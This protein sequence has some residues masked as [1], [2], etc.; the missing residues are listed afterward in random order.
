MKVKTS[1]IQAWV[2]DRSKTMAPR[3]LRLFVTMVRGAFNAAVI[4]RLVAATPFQRIVLPK[5]ERERVVPL[6]VEQVAVVDE[7]GDQYKA[8][9]VT[10]AGLGLRIGELLTLRAEDVDFL[11]REVRIVHQIDRTTREFVPP[12]TARSRRTVPL[13]NVV[14]LELA[15]HI[16]TYA[17]AT[18]GLLFHT[19]DGLPYWHDWYG[20][21]VFKQAATKAKCPAGTTS[22]DLRHHYASVLLAAGESVV[23]VA[24]RL[25]HD[26]AELVLSTY[27][28]LLPHL[29]EDRTRKA[30]DA[31]WNGVA[32]GS[33]ETDTA[34]G[35]APVIMN[36]VN[37]LVNRPGPHSL[38][39][40]R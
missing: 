28:H 38:T 19:R 11:R 4:D 37:T 35:Q 36:P 26:N 10:Q 39:C 15:K 12:K 9:V 7:I 5:L 2:T 30:I 8:M 13:P 29:L 1:E 40:C 16:Q 27:G 34:Q 17:P 33:G 31:A 3:T 6:T 22:H 32:E 21:K 20:N 25:G 14:S 24:E 18:N 23:A